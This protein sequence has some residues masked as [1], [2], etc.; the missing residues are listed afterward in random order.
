MDNLG[1]VFMAGQYV[2]HLLVESLPVD[3]C[4]HNLHHTINVVKGARKI[5]K[6]AGLSQ[7]EKEVLLL[8]AWF[9]DTGFIEVYQGHEEASTRIAEDY[10]QRKGYPQKRINLVKQCILATKMPQD[11]KDLLSRIIC[12]ADLYHLAL[13]EY[14]NLQR[15]LFEEWKKVLGKKTTYIEWV[16]D[17]HEFISSHKYWSSYG[18]KH[19]EPKKAK[20]VERSK[21]IE[22][23]VLANYE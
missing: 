9:H 14:M 5:S 6:G 23:Y 8:A 18:R 21:S 10:L 22:K 19:L 3:M 2:T 20:N 15:L 16:A 12:D 1:I 11:P 4:F 17:N 13:P 7:K